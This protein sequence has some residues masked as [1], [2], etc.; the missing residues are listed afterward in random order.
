MKSLKEN[1]VWD[2]VELPEGRKAVGSKWV[3][4]TKRNT[5]GEIEHY[6]ARLVTQ[7]FSQKF[8][9]DYDETF[10][11]VV[12]L[13]SIR[14]LIAM[15][16]QHDLHLPQVDVTTAFFNGNLEK[17]KDIGDSQRDLSFQDRSTWPVN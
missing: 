13:E 1:N 6:K 3:F 9:S 17:R 5:N 4:E 11:P 10:C 12:R 8:G 16:V 7:G 2:L 14:T 15:A